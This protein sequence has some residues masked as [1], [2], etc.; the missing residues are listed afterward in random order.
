MLKIAL[1]VLRDGD[2]AP[3]RAIRTIRFHYAINQ[4]LRTTVCKAYFI[5]MLYLWWTVW[6][7][8]SS[9]VYTRW[10]KQKSGEEL[11]FT[12]SKFKPIFTCQ[13]EEILCLHLCLLLTLPHSYILYT[14]I[15]K[16]SN[17]SKATRDRESKNIHVRKLFQQWK[18]ASTDNR[19]SQ[20]VGI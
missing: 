3:F 15:T 6:R 1:A 8:Q 12:I 13:I 18:T 4:Q 5:Y 20:A 19:N 9:V 7:A 2:W 16:R 17:F 11:R 10:A 14:R